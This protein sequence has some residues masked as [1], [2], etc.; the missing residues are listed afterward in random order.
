MAERSKERTKRKFQ[1]R[2]YDGELVDVAA[3]AAILGG[4]EKAIRARIARGQIPFLRLGG[5]ILMRRSALVEYLRALEVVS[6]AQA[7]EAIRRSSA[8]GGGPP[9]A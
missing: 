9:A 8:D 6:V 2:R 5:R 1:R 3:S 7:V 4:T